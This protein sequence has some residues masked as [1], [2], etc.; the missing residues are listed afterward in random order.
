MEQDLTAGIRPKLGPLQF[1]LGVIYYNYPNERRLFG[2]DGAILTPANT[3]YRELAGKVL[4]DQPGG[5]HPGRQRVLRRQLSTQTI[6]GFLLR[7]RRGSCRNGI[8]SSSEA[9]GCWRR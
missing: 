7:R 6:L 3:G 2:P 4:R 9:A 5:A 1:D 8:I